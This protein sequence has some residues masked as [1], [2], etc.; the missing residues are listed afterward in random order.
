[1]ARNHQY[2]SW[3][4]TRRP[5]NILGPDGTIIT[6]TGGGP[7]RTD[8]AAASSLDISVDITAVSHT[9]GSRG[10]NSNNQQRPGLTY[11]IR[12]SFDGGI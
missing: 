8:P 9:P 10:Y 2:S 6:G 12:R 4:R 1:M 3:G 5:K 11:W 7:M